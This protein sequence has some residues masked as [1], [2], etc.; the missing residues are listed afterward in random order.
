LKPTP[1]KP[2]KT[3]PKLNRNTPPRSES[4]C[5]RSLRE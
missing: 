2:Y 3:K 5:L 1:G 4:E